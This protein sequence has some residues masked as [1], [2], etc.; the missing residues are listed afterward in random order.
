MSKLNDILVATTGTVTTDA[1]EYRDLAERSAYLDIIT[2]AVKSGLASY[3][4]EDIIETVGKC[5]DNKAAKQAPV[6]PIP[7]D[8]EDT[9]EDPAAEGAGED[10]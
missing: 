6:V 9:Q 1:E 5:L 4:V 7:D 10:A 2:T 8:G 3:I